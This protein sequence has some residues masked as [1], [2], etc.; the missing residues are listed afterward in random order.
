MKNPKT[1]LL[2]KI[3]DQKN[4]YPTLKHLHAKHVDDIAGV[5]EQ[6]ATETVLWA[7]DQVNAGKQI[8]IGDVTIKLSK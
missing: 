4:I 1:F 6:Y 7:I 5:M 3:I 2:E 8:S